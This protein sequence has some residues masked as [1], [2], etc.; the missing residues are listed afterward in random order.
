L[1]FGDRSEGFRAFD[2]AQKYGLPVL[3]IRRVWQVIDGEPR[4][5]YW[6]LAFRA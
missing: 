6:E 2:I 1:F 5:P 3:D 4:G